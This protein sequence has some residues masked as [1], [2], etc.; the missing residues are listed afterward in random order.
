[1]FGEQHIIGY[2]SEEQREKLQDLLPKDLISY[3]F[4]RTQT[5]VAEIEQDLVEKLQEEGYRVEKDNIIRMALPYSF[6]QPPS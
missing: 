6:P 1:M 2:E 5:Y 4:E 3:H